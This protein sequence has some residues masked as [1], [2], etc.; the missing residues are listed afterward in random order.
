MMASKK[1]S[2]LTAPKMQAWHEEEPR[3]TPE[4][5]LMA[6]L[7]SATRRVKARRV[8][9]RGSAPEE[10]TYYA[11]RCAKRQERAAADPVRPR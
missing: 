2:K 9:S 7:R 11:T 8:E 10:L 3:R 4:D 5:V 6:R 1:K